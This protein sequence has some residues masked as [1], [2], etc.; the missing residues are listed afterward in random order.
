MAS[1]GAENETL[2]EL[3]A[4]VVAISS[5]SIESHRRF[6]ERLGDLPFPLLADPDLAVAR[7]YGVA[8]ES[9]QRAIRAV[10]VIDPDGTIRRRIAPY[11]PAAPT[12]F[13]EVFEA[14]GVA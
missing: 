4:R 6:L 8:D 13:L 10:F 1:F 7:R 5:D 3:G 9:I 11:S 14:L 2:R 12:Q